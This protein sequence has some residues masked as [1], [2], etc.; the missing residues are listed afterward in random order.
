MSN[1]D[2]PFGGLSAHENDVWARFWAMQMQLPTSLDAQLKRDAGVTYFEFQALLKI[3]DSKHNSRRMTDLSEATS[4]S[5][6]HLSRVVT[7]LEKKGLVVR[8]PDP[9]DGRSTFAALT[10][11]GEKTVQ[12][13]L[14]GHVA[15]MRRV[16][17]DNLSES[18]LD[19]LTGVFSRV[20]AALVAEPGLSS[21][22]AQPAKVD[23]A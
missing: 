19:L 2:A 5:L 8:I 1:L 3:S 22:A 15:E 16:F 11:T 7:R 6:S 23:A 18:E 14:P 13:A 12:E 20:N 9:N 21:V 4:M 17:F 10:P